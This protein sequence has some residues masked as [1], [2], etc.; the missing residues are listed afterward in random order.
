MQIPLRKTFLH[1]MLYTEL[2]QET[3]ITLCQDLAYVC[4]SSTMS[5]AHVNLFIFDPFR[6]KRA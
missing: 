5:T 4:N 3:S 6:R 2:I 1:A